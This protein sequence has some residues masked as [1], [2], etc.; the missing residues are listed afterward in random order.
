MYL[1]QWHHK[2]VCLLFLLQVLDKPQ[3]QLQLYVSIWETII[4]S[5]NWDNSPRSD[6]GQ[7][8]Q[9]YFKHVLWGLDSRPNKVHLLQFYQPLSKQKGGTQSQDN[10]PPS[11][12]AMWHAWGITMFMNLQMPISARGISIC[13][14][15]VDAFCYKY[16]TTNIKNNLQHS[17]IV[18]AI[19]SA[20]GN[21]SKLNYP[22]PIRFFRY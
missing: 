5:E 11:A 18:M 22:W 1:L 21:T 2:T 14:S 17:S 12:S 10:V 15:I 8:H 6:G 9:G 4:Q 19:H 3:L 13:N 7:H 20:L 16:W